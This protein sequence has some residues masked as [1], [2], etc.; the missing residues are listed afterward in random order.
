MFRSR[1]WAV[2]LSQNRGRKTNNEGQKRK[3]TRTI[4]KESVREKG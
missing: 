4:N 2:H 3:V 1:K